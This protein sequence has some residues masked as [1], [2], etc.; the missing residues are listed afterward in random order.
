MGCVSS[1]DIND[2]H[3]NIFQVANV[4]DSGVSI[5]PGKLQVTDTELVLYQRNKTP[6]RWPLRSLRKYGFDSDVFSFEC[7]RR[8]ATGEGIYAFKTRKAEQL[9]NLMQQKINGNTSTEE[10]GGYN[11]PE[12]NGVPQACPFRIPSQ[13]ESIAM[14][15]NVNRHDSRPGSIVGLAT[16]SP[17][18][19]TDPWERNN[20]QRHQEP[21]YLNVNPARAEMR[22]YQ[23]IEVAATLSEVIDA[24]S[25]PTRAYM[26]V[27][28]LNHKPNEQ[29][30][31]YANINPDDCDLPA[32][33]I[34]YA[35]LDLSS[36]SR[37]PSNT[38]S[39]PGSPL[40]QKKSYATI[41]FQ[42]T[43]ALSQSIN[44]SIDTEEGSRK[45]RHNSTISDITTRHSNS[46][47]D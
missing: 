30:R 8:C 37:H 5:C 42:K 40:K 9:F 46:V 19:I 23:N 31:D 44:P 27:E 21:T 15:Q 17:P 29:A 39:A 14:P 26:N 34:N 35:A 11:S 4:N 16:P 3:P 22:N 18:P 1:K 32:P 13:I 10:N 43:N 47:S 20:N 7:G 38:E 41:D 33:S 25:D 24:E 45:T 6:T 36:S 28:A 2:T 12:T